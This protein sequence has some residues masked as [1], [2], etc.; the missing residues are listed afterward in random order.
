MLAIWKREVKSYF[1]NV[2]GWLFLAAVF[3]LYGL[4]FYAYN[5]RSGYPYISYALSA[6]AFIMLIAV[7]VLTMRSLAEERHSKTDQLILTAPVSVGKIVV[8]KYLAM[9]TV[10]S[11]DMLLIALTPFLLMRY[12]TIP[13]GESYA[14]VL[15]FW[16]YGC[17]C[18]AVGIFISS[19]TESQVIA[20]VLTFAAL[21]LG[22][23]MD[24][25][26]SLISQ[27][28]NLLTKVLRCYDLYSPLDQFMNGTVDISGMIYYITIIALFLFLTGQAI[29]KRRWSISS[30]KIATGVFSTGFIAA[31]VAVTVVVN[32]FVAELPTTWTSLDVTANQI[33][34][35]TDDTKDYLKSLDEDV[36]IYVLVSDSSKDNTLDETLQRYEAM[37]SHITVSYVNP[38]VNP[39]FAAQYTDSSVTTNSMIVVSGK[40]SRVIDYNDVYSYSYDYST[41]S[42]NIDGYDAEGQLTS[43]IEYVT[44][45]SSELPVIYEVTGHGETALSGGFSE[46]VEKANITLSDLT[47]LTEDAVPEDAQAVIINGPTSDFSEDDADKVIAYINGGGKVLITTD[48]EHQGLTNFESILSAC[49]MS[50]VS[51]IVMENDK[52]YYY[53]NVPYYLLPTVDSCAYTSSVNGGYIFAPYSEGITYGEDT[54]DVTYTALLETT[55]K[56]VSKTDAA[57][58]KTS[59]FEDGDIEGPFTIAAAMEKQIDEDTVA[60]VVVAGCPQLFTDS[61]DQVVSGNNAKL[62]NDII[63]QLAGNET[64][65]ASVIPTKEY[66]LSAITV[67][68]AAAIAYGMVL[69]IVIPLAL[70]IAGI[71]IWVKRRKK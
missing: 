43:A 12:G 14:A 1:Q 67:D 9:V 25:I 22:Y 50:R 26:C 20:A 68:A 71:V 19:L 57:N 40:R 32:L 52:S 54:D 13:L 11:I 23:M 17:T 46:A 18:I 2:I 45:E 3:V 38:A 30:K 34:S 5:L 55:E 69:M 62:F 39:S 15:G 47:L 70:L 41:Y 44:M 28:G 35:I 37:S 61:T 42:R 6:I 8:G 66:E 48:Y 24:S 27:A 49:G 21:F 51:G 33:Y 56:A 10:F 60:K 29:Q 7:P 31:A 53:S 59:E 58:A 64:A 36:N 65:S 63:S 4:Y 16:L